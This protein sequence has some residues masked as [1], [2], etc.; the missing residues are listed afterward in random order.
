MTTTLRP[1][2]PERHTDGGGRARAYEVCVN[3][4]PV[5]TVRLATDA[6]LGPA[7]GRIERLGLDPPTAPGERVSAPRG[8]GVSS[9]QWA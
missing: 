7:A 2:A 5:G 9:G 4:R 8:E 3:G 1:T 6:R